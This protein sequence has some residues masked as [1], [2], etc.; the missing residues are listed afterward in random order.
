MKEINDIEKLPK[1]FEKNGETFMLG[2]GVTA[3]NKLVIGYNHITN[4][5]QKLI[6]IVVDGQK[7][8]SHYLEMINGK[9]FEHYIGSADT[10]EDAV[11]QLAEI[12]M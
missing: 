6:S 1:S 12:V 9:D 8:E 10:L 4:K 3:W 5:S 11:N 7:G 2:M